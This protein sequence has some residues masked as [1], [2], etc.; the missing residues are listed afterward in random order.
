[1]TVGGDENHDRAMITPSLKMS[2]EAERSVKPFSYRQDPKVPR[3][4]DGGPVFV[5][6]GE[7]VMCSRSAMFVLK[8]DRR[9]VSRFAAAQSPLGQM[10]LEH[11]GFKTDDFETMLLLD[12]GLPYVK[13]QAVFGALRIVGFPWSL[14]RIFNLLPRV[15]LDRAY[16]TLARNRFRIF[17]RR[18]SCYLPAPD[19]AHRFLS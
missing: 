13:S 5:F 7:C 14:A 18:E 4:D 17:G 16:D 10:L 11:Y 15:L 1:M 19:E 9:G 6:D 8:H 3:F 2:P 12:E